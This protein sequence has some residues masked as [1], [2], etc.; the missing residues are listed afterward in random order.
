MAA[1]IRET[2]LGYLR[3]AAL[4]G[5][6]GLASAYAVFHILY[7]M[8]TFPPEGQPS[9]LLLS[10]V[11]TMPALLAGLASTD[12]VP[13]I[14]QSFLGS[15]VGYVLSVALLL[16]PLALGL[17]S[18]AP[19]AAP[20]FVVHYAFVYLATALFANFLVGLV[21]LAIRNYFLAKIPRP[22]PWAVQRK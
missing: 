8:A 14:F 1:R 22:A 16:S 17:Y 2:W 9:L 18:L 20:G 21:G 7:P 15:V 4:A 3:G 5:I 13:V 19:D 10:L 12:I 6:L 11:L